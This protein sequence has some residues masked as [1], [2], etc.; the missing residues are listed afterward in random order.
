M[1]TD[2]IVSKS[3]ELL[4]AMIEIPSL[5]KEEKDL[6]DYLEIKFTSWGLKPTRSGNNLWIRNEKWDE[7]KPVILLNSHIDTVRPARGW[8][9][10]PYRATHEEDRIT[11]LGSN[12]A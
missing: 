6:A 7:G 8:T 10:D 3:V 9:Y 11:G 5:S 2:E 1:V 4:I 12:D